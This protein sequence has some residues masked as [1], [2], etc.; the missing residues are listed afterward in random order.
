MRICRLLRIGQPINASIQALAAA[1]SPAHLDGSDLDPAGGSG[2]PGAG[3]AAAGGRGTMGGVGATAG[4]V[5]NAAARTTS[6]A[7]G[8]ATTATADVARTSEGATGGVNSD[9]QLTLK[10][11]GVFGLEGLNLSAAGSND[12]QG[13]VITSKGKNVHL[14]GGTQML[15]VAGTAAGAAQN[16]PKKSD[17]AKPEPKSQPRQR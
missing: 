13:T 6:G 5:T 15:L 1:Q 17:G 4:G 9:G 12:A 11:R 7:V 14:D 16:E 3:S 8:A 2:V 10:S